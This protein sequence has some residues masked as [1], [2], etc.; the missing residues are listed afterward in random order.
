MCEFA[1]QTVDINGNMCFEC[2]YG[3]CCDYQIEAVDIDGDE[4]LI[5][6]DCPN[7]W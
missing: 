3:D 6:D 4:I 5:C 7:C 1:I 2:S